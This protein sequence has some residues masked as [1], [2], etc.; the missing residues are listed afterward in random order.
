MKTEFKVRNSA[1]IDEPYGELDKN[2]ADFEAKR[3]TIWN[4]FLNFGRPTLYHQ[5]VNVTYNLPIN[6]F[7]LTDWVSINTKY[8]ANLDWMAAPLALQRLGS[9]LQNNNHKQINSNLNFTQLYNKVPFLKKINQ[10]ANKRG[11]SG[12]RPGSRQNIVL[13]SDQDTIKK[14]FKDY[15]E[16]VVRFGMMLKNASVTY[17]QNQGTTLPGYTQSPGFF[18]QDWERMAPGIPFALGSQLSIEQL[19]ADNG[20]IT[21]DSDLNQFYRT[22]NSENL[23]F[24]STIEPVKGFRIEVTANKLKNSSMQEIFRANSNGDFESFN[25]VETGSYSIS[26][27]TWNTAFKGNDDS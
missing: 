19:A 6:K 4:N 1:S 25:P 18:G 21:S 12:M 20:W 24:R 9:T 14:T 26:Y 23:N 3:D 7:P 27:L 11:R 15:L 22:S 10:K 8:T 16:Y 17:S 2:D 5:T 13:P